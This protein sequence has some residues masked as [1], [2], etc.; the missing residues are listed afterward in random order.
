MIRDSRAILDGWDCR[1]FIAT[2]LIQEKE[3]IKYLILS[4]FRDSSWDM[5]PI[6]FIVF[7]EQMRILLCSGY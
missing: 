6:Q 7:M 1:S 4:E 5:I 2:I 3:S